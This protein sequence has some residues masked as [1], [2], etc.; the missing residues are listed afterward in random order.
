MK[1]TPSEKRRII[2]DRKFAARLALD[3]AM[4]GL[5][6]AYQLRQRAKEHMAGNRMWQAHQYNEAFKEQ[7]A[8]VTG[9]V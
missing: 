9:K 8:K 5:C 2:A 1:L 7:F 3:K 6:R 4:Q